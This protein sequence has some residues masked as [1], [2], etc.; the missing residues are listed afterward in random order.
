VTLTNAAMHH[1]G[2]YTPYEGYKAT[3]YPVRVLVRGAT[4][5]DDG[6]VTGQPGHGRYLARAPYEKITPLG[7]FPT[8]FNPVDRKI[9]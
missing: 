5:F 2:D 9:V 4:V 6:K 3:G 1:G 7:R 8:P